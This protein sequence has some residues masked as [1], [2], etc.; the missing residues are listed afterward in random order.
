MY[1]V[2]PHPNHPN[3]RAQNG[4]VTNKFA[5]RFNKNYPLLSPNIPCC[6]KLCPLC[7]NI[8]HSHRVNSP[9]YGDIHVSFN[10]L[11]VCVV[12]VMWEE[13]I[14]GR[15]ESTGEEEVESKNTIF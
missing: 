13:G 3:E 2:T 9:L 1:A 10:M 6:L 4:R 11:C 8:F 14:G 7:F 12:C 15:G 5:E